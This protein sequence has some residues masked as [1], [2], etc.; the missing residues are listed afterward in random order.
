MFL[1]H[2]KSKKRNEIKL[3]G[4]VQI[5]DTS[6]F[7][8]KNKDGNISLKTGKEEKLQKAIISR[9]VELNPRIKKLLNNYKI[10]PNI[11]TKTLKELL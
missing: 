6:F 3:L 11:N 5:N 1:V 7:V 8:C 9:M 2:P 10:K 4:A